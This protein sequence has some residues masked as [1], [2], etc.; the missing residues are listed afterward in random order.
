MFKPE[1]H[2]VD[3]FGGAMGEVAESAVFNFAVFTVRGAQEHSGISAFA[4][5]DNGGVEIHSG[6]ISFMFFDD[7]QLFICK[8]YI[9]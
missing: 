8:K 2:G 9:N 3:L 4:G 5:T 1:T 7:S 6:Y